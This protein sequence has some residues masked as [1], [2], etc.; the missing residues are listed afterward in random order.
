MANTVE[1]NQ[2]EITIQGLIGQYLAKRPTVSN[3]SDHL[4][5]DT[6]S[7]FI[8]GSLNERQATPVVGHLVKCDFCRHVSA[9]L[10]RLD[11][12][13]AENAP[14]TASVDQAPG[15][16]SE[17]LSGLFSKIFG[18]VDGAVFAHS[19]D[20]KDKDEESAKDDESDKDK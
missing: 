14:A 9:E 3:N 4:D 19:E 8:E 10:I 1:M 12:E 7:A 13:F 18:T 20:D 16:I 6:L 5:Q 17:V 15:K 2:Q 11:M